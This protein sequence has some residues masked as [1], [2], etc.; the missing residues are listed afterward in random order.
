MTYERSKDIVVEE[1]TEGEAKELTYLK[2]QR[3]LETP[4]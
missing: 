1:K 2:S 4:V 3:D